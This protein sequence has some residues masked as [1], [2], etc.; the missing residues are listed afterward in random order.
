MSKFISIT[1]LI[2]KKIEEKDKKIINKIIESTKNNK[3]DEIFLYDHLTPINIDI[4]KLKLGKL[5]KGDFFNNLKIEEIKNKEKIIDFETASGKKIIKPSLLINNESELNIPINIDTPE[6]RLLLKQN[7]SYINILSNIVLS[8]TITSNHIAG[9]NNVK[10]ILK[11]IIVWPLMNPKIFTG[12]LGP[13]KGLLL[14]GPPG[15]GKTMLGKYVASEV[16]AVFFSISASSLLSKFI[17]ES[18]K[19]VRGLFEIAN[20]YLSVIFIDEIDSIL[21]SRNDGEHEATRRLKTEFLIQMDGINKNNVL[22]IGATNRP[23]DI[24]E[25]ARRRLVKR[26]YVPLPDIEGIKEI[27]KNLMINCEN[28]LTECDLNEISQLLKGYS[29]SDTFNL[30]R[31]AAME[32]V[33]EF[34]NQKGELRKVNINDFK[35]AIN[36][37]R[38]SVNEKEL[39]EYEKW[40][41]TYGSL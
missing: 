3:N 18:E 22:L 33:R 2:N 23:Q 27:I 41:E 30:C 34:M 40:N 29:G 15:T 31:E 37:I 39:I 16:K 12:L 11:E 32:P 17:G 35:K 1:P 6:L 4:T 24:D 19:M 10:Q 25:A 14:F 9:L 13:P 28:N 5:I 8:D 20:L 26:V 36:Q 21:S 7:P 38:R